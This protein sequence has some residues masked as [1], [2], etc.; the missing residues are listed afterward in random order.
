MDKKERLKQYNKLTD[1]QK[2]LLTTYLLELGLDGEDAEAF[3]DDTLE[4]L[5][6]YPCLLYTS[7]S[8][9]D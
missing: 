6:N 9:R 1:Y 3:I 4:N 7:P 5:N 8:P 2:D